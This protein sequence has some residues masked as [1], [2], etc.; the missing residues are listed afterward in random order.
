MRQQLQRHASAPACTVTA[1]IAGLVLASLA[2]YQSPAVL[3]TMGLSSTGFI[4]QVLLPDTAARHC[5]NLRPLPCFRLT[6]CSM[7]VQADEALPAGGHSECVACMHLQRYAAEHLLI[8]PRTAC[9][10]R[11]CNRNTCRC[12][13]PRRSDTYAWMVQR[14]F[15]RTT[16]TPGLRLPGLRSGCGTLSASGASSGGRLTATCP[17]I[18]LPFL[19]ALQRIV[20]F[21]NARADPGVTYLTSESQAV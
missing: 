2:L 4:R 7:Y 21:P 19:F 20:G 15:C 9:T 11:S 1:V 12:G 6:A 8:Y 14:P 5:D 17:S 3:H 18:V 13:V 16:H 10:S